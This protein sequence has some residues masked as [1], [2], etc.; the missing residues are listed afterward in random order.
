MTG[1]HFTPDMFLNNHLKVADPVPVTSEYVS[2]TSKRV[3]ATADLFK[4]FPKTFIYYVSN[5]LSAL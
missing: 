4:G 3:P 1:L 5:G 2:C